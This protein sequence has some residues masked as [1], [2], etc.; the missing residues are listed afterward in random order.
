MWMMG[1]KLKLHPIKLWNVFYIMIMLEIPNP[2]IKERKRLIIYYKNYGII[3]VKK[4]L[5]ANHCI[6]VK[7][8]EEEINNEIIWNVEKQPTK[9]RPNVW[10]N[11]IFIFLL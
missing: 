5:N 10:T 3:V 4:H 9:K 8:F 11:A 2:I 7:K 1:K 6:I